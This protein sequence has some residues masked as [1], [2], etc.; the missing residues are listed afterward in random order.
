MARNPTVSESEILEAIDQV[1]G[2]A[3]TAVELGEILGMTRAGV[4]NRLLQL[5]EDRLV[6]RKTVGAS[7]VIWYPTDSS[8]TTGADHHQ[9]ATR[10]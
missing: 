8:R 2:P 3:A 6:D 10:P 4:R 9:S 1:E 5:K 7:A